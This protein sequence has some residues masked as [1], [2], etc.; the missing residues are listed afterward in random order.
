MPGS[1]GLYILVA[2]DMNC[3][4][5]LQKTHNTLQYYQ[6]YTRVCITLPTPLQ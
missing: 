6:I 5:A 3:Q 1:K 2:F 4:I